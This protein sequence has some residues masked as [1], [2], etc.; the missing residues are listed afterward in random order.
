M[1]WPQNKQ[2]EVEKQNTGLGSNSIPFIIPCV[3]VHLYVYK[4]SASDKKGNNIH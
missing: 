1:N 4:I 3:C 2:K